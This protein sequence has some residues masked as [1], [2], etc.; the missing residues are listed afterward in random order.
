VVGSTVVN[1]DGTFSLTAQASA[2]GTIQAVT[3]DVW[4]QSSNTAQVTVASNVP[5]F[6]QFY[7][8]T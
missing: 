5:T 4:G 8:R 2:L 1:A 7:G 3:E 6:T